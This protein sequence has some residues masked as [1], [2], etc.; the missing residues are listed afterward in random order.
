M[1]YAPVES[2]VVLV[3][4]KPYAIVV[5]YSK[6]SVVAPAMA[7]RFPLRVAVVA[8]TAVA[9][10]VTT[11]DERQGV[12]AVVVNDIF[13]PYT[14]PAPVVMSLPAVPAAVRY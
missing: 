5:P 2:A 12:A 14:I 7:V 3:V 8:V 10:L 11:V 4:A 9:G 1:L 13:V 6:E